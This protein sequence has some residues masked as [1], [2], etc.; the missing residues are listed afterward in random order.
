MPHFLTSGLRETGDRVRAAGLKMED[1]P[2]PGSAWNPGSRWGTTEAVRPQHR[3]GSLPL[4][5][6]L[7][8]PERVEQ[9]AQFVD[10]WL[11]GFRR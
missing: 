5:G 11:R 9:D 1:G 7:E 4:M 10:L 3:V 2:I 6:V 8:V